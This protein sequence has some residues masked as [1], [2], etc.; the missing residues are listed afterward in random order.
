[1][2]SIVLQNLIENSDVDE[3]YFVRDNNF[4]KGNL[5]IKKTFQRFLLVYV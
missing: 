2:Q 5:I 4:I 3:F 1:M